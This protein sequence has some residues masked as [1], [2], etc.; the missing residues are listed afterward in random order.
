MELQA[1]RS[2]FDHLLLIKIE[3]M[4]AFANN[5]KL[6]HPSFLCLLLGLH[7]RHYFHMSKATKENHKDDIDSYGD[8][9]FNPIDV[10]DICKVHRRMITLFFNYASLADLT[11]IL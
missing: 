3:Y 5:S 4:W 7:V 11:H 2:C 10:A 9:Y 6:T 1:F 8:P